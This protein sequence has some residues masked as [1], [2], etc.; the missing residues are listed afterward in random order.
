MNNQIILDQLI[1]NIVDT[2]NISREKAL[3][4]LLFQI[5]DDT[6]NRLSVQDEIF[7]QCMS[8]IDKL[9]QLLS[10]PE[11]ILGSEATK[12]G[13]IAELIEVYISNANDILEGKTPTSTFDNIGRTSPIDYIMDGV[14]VQSKFCNNLNDTLKE[15]IKHVEK[16]SQFKDDGLYKI[17]SDQFDILQKIINGEQSSIASPKTID[18]VL[19]KVAQIEKITGKSIND[20]ID[21]SISTYED[22][23][24]EN[25]NDT[26][27]RYS[28]KLL[29]KNDFEKSKIKEEANQ[30]E[31]YALDEYAPSFKGAMKAGTYAAIIGSTISAGI[32]IYSKYR[33]E[34]KSLID[35]DIEDWKEIGFDFTK[36]GVRGGISGF[37]IYELTNY[38]NLSAPMAGAFV[39]ATIGVATLADKYNKGL[40]SAS[41]F[42]V[43]GEILCVDASLTALGGALGQTLI[44]IPIVG[45]MVGCMATQILTSIGKIY[46]EKND[47]ML[48]TRLEN[49]YLKYEAMLDYNTMLK[50]KEINDYYENLGGILLASRNVE[51][52][53][54]LKFNLSIDLARAVG[55]DDNEI[56]K[57]K[58]EIDNYF[59]S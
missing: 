28:N 2:L 12:H 15:V 20:I 17:P 42:A 24:I 44:P 37:S 7:L 4:L 52:N 31:Q 34:D 6:I 22:V 32:K 16:Y 19:E 35:F 50:M 43:E 54:K 30:K 14:K 23:Q 57:S 49:E 5:E 18:S 58:E 21:S 40:I 9:N 13:E 46:L 51:V 53:Y 27:G 29:N 55:I 33:V 8:Q 48:F 45:A 1:A 39:S 56:L 47:S 41:D 38:T 25:A 11:N 3:E 26:V 36:G 10:K 59:L